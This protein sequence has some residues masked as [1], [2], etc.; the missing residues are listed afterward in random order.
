MARILSFNESA[1]KLNKEEI[2]KE[3]FSVSH[4][5]RQM[6]VRWVKSIYQVE[7]KARGNKIKIHILKQ[8]Q[9]T[10]RMMATC[11]YL[12]DFHCFL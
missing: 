8:M 9:Y 4:A 1:S 7:K 3:V 12:F 5:Q 2:E 6:S 11:F 10:F